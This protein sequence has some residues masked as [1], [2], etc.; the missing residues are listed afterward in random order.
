MKIYCTSIGH[1]TNVFSPIPTSLDNYREGLLYMPSTGEGKEILNGPVDNEDVGAIALARGH[2]IHLGLLAFAQPSRPLNAGDYKLLKDEIINNL[3]AALPVDMVLMFLHGAQVAEGCNDCEGDIIQSVRAIVGPDVPI[4]IEIDLHGNITDKMIDNCD[5]LIA[6]KEYPH[7]DFGDRAVE[8]VDIME[9]VIKKKCKPA[10]AFVRVPM[11]GSFFTT[12]EPMRS[13]VDEMIALEGK[14]GVLSISLG[15]GFPW[16]DI[17]EAGAGVLVVTDNDKAKANNMAEDIAKRFFGLRHKIKAPMLSVAE[18]LDRAAAADKWPVT[19]ADITDNPGGGAAGDSTF[20]LREILNRGMKDVA[21]AM[22]WDPVAVQMATN[23]GIGAQISLRIG[24]KAGPMSGN[25]VDIRI[26]V[27]A[28]A[29]NPTQYAQGQDHSLG[30]CAA[31]E[32]DGVQIVLNSLR[33]QT[34]TPECFTKLGID[35]LEKKLLVV[36]SHQHFHETFSPFSSDII[37]ATPPGTVSKNFTKIP[38]KNI[39]R[40]VWPID[41]VPFTVFDREWS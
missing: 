6:C 2:E 39:T 16:S 13:F 24:G 41:K 18:A 7:T 30:L 21:L 14:E 15:H 4:G 23:A 36:K 26:K 29:E 5:V 32:V 10:S 19:I 40:P 35:P 9:Q 12:R 37:Y 27:I 11:F 33:Q 20:I 17:P 28:L 22:I 8:L 38:F 34:F 31:V 3:K 1:E 25:P